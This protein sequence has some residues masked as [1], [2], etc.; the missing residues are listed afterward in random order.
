MRSTDLSDASIEDLESLIAQARAELR[1]RASANKSC[2]TCG[3]S[4]R[5]RA[6]AV[7]CSARCRTSLHRLRKHGK[8]NMVSTIDRVTT[9]GYEGK[10]LDDFIS[11]LRIQNVKA[12][13]D[14]RLNAISRKR[15]FSKT[16]LSTRLREEGIS[17]HH[18]KMLG[19]ARENR[20]GYA[21]VDTPAGNTARALFRSS[22]DDADAVEAIDR[23][24]ELAEH[25]K[26]ALF[27]YE[28]DVAHCHREQVLERIRDRADSMLQAA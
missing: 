8:I 22:L 9:I 5:G 1:R 15:G 19:N 13:V 16:A 27:C 18:L 6:D 26:V 10:T 2:I 3:A 21:E 28:H 23:I 24:L 20:A 11:S 17:Y 7:T 12:L 14:V 4:F 25:Q